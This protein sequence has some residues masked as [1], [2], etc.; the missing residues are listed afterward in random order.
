MEICWA[1]KKECRDSIAENIHKAA[2]IESNFAQ[3]LDS[4]TKHYFLKINS[5]YN[6]T[7]TREVSF[8]NTTSENP[9]S[10][11]LFLM[12]SI[13]IQKRNKKNKDLIMDFAKPITLMKEE[14]VSTTE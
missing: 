10:I 7:A 9:Q 13:V 11:I 1:N 12:L 2:I 3:E 4:T 5:Y 6:P 8:L 14:Y